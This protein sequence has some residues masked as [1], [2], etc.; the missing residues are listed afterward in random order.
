MHHLRSPGA[1]SLPNRDRYRVLEHA[2]PLFRHCVNYCVSSKNSPLELQDG[3]QPQIELWESR[4]GSG[5]RQ[6]EIVRNAP[7]RGIAAVT[8]H[9][10]ADLSEAS[11][12]TINATRSWL[13]KVVIGLKLCPFA[14]SVYVTERIRYVVSEQRSAAGLKDELAQELRRLSVANESQHETTLLIHPHVLQ[15]FADYNE[16]LNEA[17]A[18][19]ADG[20]FD[21]E[22]QVASFHPSYRFHGTAPDD[23]ENFTNRS[24]YPMLHLLREASVQR[25][26]EGYPDVET[27]PTNNIQT[28]R[29]LG[30]VRLRQLLQ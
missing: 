10:D 19:I 4:A 13:E 24:P 21:G 26:V 20:G 12:L 1:R 14:R 9:N 7:L 29:G 2:R 25:A 28:L 11:K 23:I 22:L 5:M 6:A 16:F 18:A 27:I 3:T 30:L 15:N 17:D 8:A